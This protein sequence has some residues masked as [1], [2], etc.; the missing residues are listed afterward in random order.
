VCVVAAVYLHGYV[1]ASIGLE[2]PSQKEHQRGGRN[3]ST[4]LRRS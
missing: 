3:G 2:Q 4:Q 1:L